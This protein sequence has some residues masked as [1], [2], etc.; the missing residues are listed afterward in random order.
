MIPNGEGCHYVA[1]KKLSALFR[2]KAL[3]KQRLFLLF[4]LSSFFYNK[5]QA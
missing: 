1:V 5:K 3:K 2:E 4:E